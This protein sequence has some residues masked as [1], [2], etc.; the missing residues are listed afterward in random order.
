MPFFYYSQAQRSQKRE[1]KSDELR[2]EFSQS[3]IVEY[4][5]HSKVADGIIYNPNAK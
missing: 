3:T 5:G 4:T 2:L 1:V